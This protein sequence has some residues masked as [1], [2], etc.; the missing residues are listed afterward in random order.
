MFTSWSLSTLFFFWESLLLNLEFT[1][2][3]R[4]QASTCLHS[5]PTSAGTTQSSAFPWVLETWTQHS[6]LHSGHFTLWAISL[7]HSLRLAFAYTT[8]FLRNTSPLAASWRGEGRACDPPALEIP[9]FHFQKLCPEVPWALTEVLTLGWGDLDKA[10]RPHASPTPSITLGTLI[11]ALLCFGKDSL[12][13]NPA[14]E[15]RNHT[16]EIMVDAVGFL[17]SL[18]SGPASSSIRIVL[19][20]L[21]KWEDH[22]L[23]SHHHQPDCISHSPLP[24]CHSPEQYRVPLK[25]HFL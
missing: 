4:L 3:A 1:N 10:L 6:C 25:R 23:D 2:S 20:S 12:L 18:S 14:Q 5:H 19:G 9:I 21:R 15:Q 7:A 16:S 13:A 24:L 22:S 17:I 11:L 8:L